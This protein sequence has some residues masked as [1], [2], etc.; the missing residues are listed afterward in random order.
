MRGHSLVRGWL[1]AG[2]VTLLTVA[3]G[4]AAAFGSAS[5]TARLYVDPRQE[6]LD[7]IV[8][9]LKAHDL[10]DALRMAELAS[11][12]IADWFTSGTPADVRAGV[13]AVVRKASARHEVPVL[14]A[15]YVPGRDCSQYSAGGAPDT[16]AY[17]AWIDGFAAGIGQSRAIVILEPDGL[18]LS[19]DQCGGT[20]AQQADRNA[21]IGYAVTKLS[22]H[23][24][25]YIDAGH[26]GWHAVG[27]MAQRL[28]AGNLA[29]A[30][31]FFL[32]VSNYRPDAELTRYGTMVSECVWYLTHT[33][34]ATGDQCANQYWPTADADAWYAAHVPAGVPLTHFVIDSSRNGQGPWVVPAGTYP[35]AQDWCN[36][37][38]R[39]LG[40]RPTLTTGTPLLDAYLWVKVPGESDGSCT[41][42]T[43][44]PGDPVYGNTVDP[45]AG[46]WW[47]DQA[48]TLARLASPALT[49]NRP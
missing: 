41:R 34:G 49:F 36:P 26:S 30:A 13:G 3:L 25:V 23:A 19:P 21:Q 43:A 4:G 11:Y 47:P 35:D 44:G 27:D 12:P 9:D 15:Y 20:A 1:L 22:R 24:S 14:V 32:N 33:A 10:A 28:I 18:A 17:Q 8:A 39:G 7:Q 6:M 40:A 42:G 37:P 16:A 48:H 38:D 45:A 5:R 2:L 29:G 46:A 31:G